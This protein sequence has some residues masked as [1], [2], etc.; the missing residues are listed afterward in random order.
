MRGFTTNHQASTKPGEAQ[1]VPGSGVD[2]RDRDVQSA[3]RKSGD[4]WLEAFD[5]THDHV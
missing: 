2:E 5:V 3:A 4:Y 1:C